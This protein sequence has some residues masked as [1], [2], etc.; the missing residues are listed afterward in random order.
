[1]SGIRPSMLRACMYSGVQFLTYE[2][3]RDKILGINYSQK[4]TKEKETTMD[5]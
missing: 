5:Q 4:L 1:M 3:V 2:T